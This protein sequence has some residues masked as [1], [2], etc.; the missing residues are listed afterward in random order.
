MLVY[1]Y[2]LWANARVPQD[3]VA[4]VAQA[5]H[6]NVADLKATSPLWAEFDPAQ[7]GRDVGVPY[8]PGAIKVYQAKGVWKR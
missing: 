5:L 8:H 3:T 2:A 7:L 6:D 1:D 4:K